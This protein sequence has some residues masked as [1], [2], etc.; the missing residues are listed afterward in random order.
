MLVH[1]FRMAWRL[2]GRGIAMDEVQIAR[3][4]WGLKPDKLGR[5]PALPPGRSHSDKLRGVYRG[6]LTSLGVGE[7][8]PEVDHAALEALGHGTGASVRPW[9][10]GNRGR[11]LSTVKSLVSCWAHAYE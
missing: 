11:I 6:A 4:A 8:L 1:G 2:L 10:G 7:C 9:L 5:K 3:R